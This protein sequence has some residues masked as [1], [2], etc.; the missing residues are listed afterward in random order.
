MLLV[1]WKALS[2]TGIKGVLRFYMIYGCLYQ[3]V[4]AMLLLENGD[5]IRFHQTSFLYNTSSS[6]NS[7]VQ[8]IQKCRATR[9]QT[10]DIRRNDHWIISTGAK[11]RGY[12]QINTAMTPTLVTSAEV[13]PS[14]NI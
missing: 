5:S 7:F 6:G 14:P 2:S 9:I 13:I 11:Y 10:L 8:V 3:P 1:G 12:F 4:Q